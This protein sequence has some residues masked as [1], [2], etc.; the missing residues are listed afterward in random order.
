MPRG[1]EQTTTMMTLNSYLNY[2]LPLV[3]G[4]ICDG[5]IHLDRHVQGE[6]TQVD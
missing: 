2:N 4:N 5:S 6:A 3:G 1:I